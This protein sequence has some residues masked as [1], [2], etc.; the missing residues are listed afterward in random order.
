L[1]HVVLEALRPEPSLLPAYRSPQ[2]HLRLLIRLPDYLIE[3]TRSVSI[4]LN[5][6]GGK[7]NL[8][9]FVT[10]AVLAFACTAVSAQTTT[11]L[12]VTPSSPVFDSNHVTGVSG[13]YAPGFALGSFASDGIAKTDM[14]FTPQALFGRSVT[15]GEVA[16]MSYW[17]KK[18]TTHNPD[19][20]DWSL[21]LYTKPYAGDVSTPTWYGDRIGTEPY[22][23][24]NLADPANTWN[25]WATDGIFNRM[26][27]YESTQGAPGANFGTYM[28]PDWATF[29]LGNAL[30]GS[31]YAG[32]AL[33]YFSIQTG[34]CCAA[35]FF[36]KVDGVRI[37]LTDGSV[38]NLNFEA[39]NQVATDKDQC[40][41]NGWA[42]RT[43][44]D[45]SLFK[46]QGDCIQY[47]NTGK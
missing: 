44:A 35:G 41:S 20:V 5:Q 16:G 32:H 10:V 29:K 3:V 45:F 34:S 19:V 47:A 39:A 38:A 7:M 43:R 2:K 26:R 30:S 23:A 37:V 27:F 8:R 22:Y 33:L 4:N 15:I 17:T 36:G 9:F 11:N 6:P 18:P 25:Q 40:K 1:G 12:V 14:Y 46:N 31:A 21:I 13:D 28:D 24:I 42:T